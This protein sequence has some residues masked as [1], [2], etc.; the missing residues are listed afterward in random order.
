[1][2]GRSKTRFRFLL[3]YLLSVH[4][5]KCDGKIVI[6]GVVRY[7]FGPVPVCTMADATTIAQKKI[8]GNRE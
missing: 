2:G 7:T 3:Q 4:L 1:M 5:Y 6:I 8:L